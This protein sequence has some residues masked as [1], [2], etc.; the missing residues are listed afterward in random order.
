MRAT[1]KQVMGNERL[2]SCDVI[3]G[4]TCTITYV[5]YEHLVLQVMGARCFVYAKILIM[6]TKSNG[7]RRNNNST[8]YL[9]KEASKRLVI[10]KENEV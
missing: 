9:R 4:E 3:S 2:A 1:S 6:Q 7:E 8:L 10:K 5:Y